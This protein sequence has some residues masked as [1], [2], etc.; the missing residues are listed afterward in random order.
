[1]SV[2]VVQSLP[3]YDDGNFKFDGKNILIEKATNQPYVENEWILI[4]EYVVDST[5]FR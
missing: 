1:M 4:H 3:A 2:L 5:A